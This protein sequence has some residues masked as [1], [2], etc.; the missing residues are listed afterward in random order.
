MR[1]RFLEEY[2]W[3]ELKSE[4]Y[5]RLSMEEVAVEFFET[6]GH[7]E[8]KTT[9]PQMDATE[10]QRKMEE[11]AAKRKQEMMDTFL[12][13]PTAPVPVEAVPPAPAPAVTAAAASRK[14]KATAKTITFGEKPKQKRKTTKSRKKK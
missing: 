8:D 12:F 9:E 2:K 5:V 3:D 7:G 10:R 1:C 13:K 11:E 14:R 4:R 6:Y